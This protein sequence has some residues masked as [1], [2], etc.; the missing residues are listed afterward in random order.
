MNV[1]TA[2]RLVRTS[3]NSIADIVISATTGSLKERQR[4][5]TVM[6]GMTPVSTLALL[7]RVHLVIVKAERIETPCGVF[8]VC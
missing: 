6:N 2:E 4:S 5:K 8:S 1:I 7:A 3:R